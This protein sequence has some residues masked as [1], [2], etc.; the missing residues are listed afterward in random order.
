MKKIELLAPV[1]NFDCLKAAIEA[2]CNAVYL[3][4]KMF[5]ARSFAGNFTKEELVEAIKYS[6]LYGVKVYLTINTIIY[7]NEVDNF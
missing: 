3:G 7:E 6:H 5:G 2:G 1:G 4:G